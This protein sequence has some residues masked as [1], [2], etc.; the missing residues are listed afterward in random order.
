MVRWKFALSITE[1]T[2]YS[3]F[4]C[5]TKW[6][7]RH[8]IGRSLPKGQEKHMWVLFCETAFIITESDI[9]R[10]FSRGAAIV[11][12]CLYL[13][14]AN[15]GMAKFLRL[16]S[17]TTL[18]S[19]LS[20]CFIAT[21]LE[22]YTD[23]FSNQRRGRAKERTG[24]CEWEAMILWGKGKKCGTTKINLIYCDILLHWSLIILWNPPAN[25][26]FGITTEMLS[27]LLAL[28]KE[29]DKPGILVAQETPVGSYWLGWA[30][31][32]INV[33]VCG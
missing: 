4:N 25:W 33:C 30:L 13:T 20:A 27:C 28:T 26:S 18:C 12:C 7:E 6:Q 10:S 32:S 9:I 5:E 14:K 19:L 17:T 22:M 21:R 8:L 29:V 2:L 16:S 23:H 31:Q 24:E 11:K 15:D 3:A 1:A